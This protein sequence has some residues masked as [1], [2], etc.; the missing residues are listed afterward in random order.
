MTVDDGQIVVLGGLI[1]DAFTDNNEKVPLV[2][3]LPLLG[4]LFRYD[5]R[6]RAKTNLMVFIKPTVVRGPHSVDALTQDRYDYLI[7]EQQRMSPDPRL[8]W[9]D[10]TRP[11]LPPLTG[12]P[13]APL[14][15]PLPPPATLIPR[16]ETPAPAE[17]PRPAQPPKAPG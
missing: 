16:S 13:S 2:G 3:D 10:T 12:S 17:P 14:V 1:Q 4:G 15:P 11:Q 7:G 8:F 5:T 6:Q 9:N